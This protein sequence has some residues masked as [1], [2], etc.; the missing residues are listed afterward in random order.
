MDFS[1]AFDTITHDLLPAKLKAYRFTKSALDLIP[2]TCARTR[3]I[4]E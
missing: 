4:K 1:K 2:Y 3:K